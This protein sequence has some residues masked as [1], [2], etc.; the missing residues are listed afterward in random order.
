MDKEVME[1]EHSQSMNDEAVDRIKAEMEEDVKVD[2]GESE[3]LAKI[4]FEDAEE[5]TLRDGKTYSIPP[6][7]LKDAR[8]LMNSLRTINVDM[9]ILNFLPT[10]DDEEDE[11]R[12]NKLYDILLIGFVGYPEVTRDYIDRYV[13]VNIAKKIIEILIGINNIKK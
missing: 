11:K 1:R 5:I 4:F 12:M 13:D 10:G 2:A 7:T 3:R 9:I 6:C 8:K